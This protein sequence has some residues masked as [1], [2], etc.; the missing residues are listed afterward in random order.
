LGD[1]EIAPNFAK[2]LTVPAL[3]FGKKP[4]GLPLP[5]FLWNL[6]CYHLPDVTASQQ[7]GTKRTTAVVKYYAVAALWLNVL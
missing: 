3:H 1:G 6:F 7:W 4:T 2:N 5:I